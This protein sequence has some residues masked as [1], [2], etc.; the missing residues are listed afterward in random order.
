MTFFDAHCDTVQ[1]ITD[2]GGGLF[3]N[4]YY[5][6]IKRILN[7]KHKHI[8]VFAAFI[9]KK[10]DA[11][12]P[13]SRCG[14]M[15]DRYYAEIERNKGLISHCNG[16]DN[17]KTALGNGKI[18][19]LLSVEGGEAIEGSLEKL[20]ELYFRG[21]RILTLC[22]NYS[23]EI[24]GSIAEENGG[25]LSAFG[26]AVVRKMND[27]GMLIDVSHISEKGFWDVLETTKKPIAATHSN[28][29]SICR[30]KRNLSDEQIRGVIKNGGC[31]GINLY[32]K[33]LS[34][35]GTCAGI[36]DILRH[37]EHILSLG[38][39][40]NIGFGS[41]FDGMDS[42]PNGI[43]N[44]GDIHKIFDEMRRIGYS[45]SLIKKISSE[46]FLNLM[47]KILI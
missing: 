45:E 44:V 5:I 23:N 20:S 37:I 2:F 6:D 13:F 17:I 24:T 42:L 19:S 11:L 14:Q 26:K 3:E 28:S 39:E 30:H 15:I 46:N 31:I 27:L 40:N 1:K 12:A 25:G 29:K 9:D 32:S 43:E 47:Q 18:A 10:N 22:W 4:T 8:Q 34:E 35:K 7:T 21:V 38:G 16:F 36:T 41:D 33:F